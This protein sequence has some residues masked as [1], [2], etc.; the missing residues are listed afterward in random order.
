MNVGCGSGL[1]YRGI[2]YREM[3]QGYRKQNGEGL[4]VCAVDFVVF[5]YE[6]RIFA[7]RIAE[8]KKCVMC[9]VV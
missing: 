8:V 1:R 4:K 9:V 5:T 7:G 2:A 6:S 3:S